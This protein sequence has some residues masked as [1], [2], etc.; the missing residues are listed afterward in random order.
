MVSQILQQVLR[1]VPHRNS[2]LHQCLYEPIH[3]K[4]YRIA[5]PDVLLE[6][7]SKH[8]LEAHL[9]LLYDH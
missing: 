9:Q 3:P 1:K 2:A 8:H 4:N 6:D 5:S 7:H